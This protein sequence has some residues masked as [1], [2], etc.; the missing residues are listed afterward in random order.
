MALPRPFPRDP[1]AVPALLLAGWALLL[2]AWV[3]GNPPFA[4]PD[5]VEHFIRA[6]GVSEGH[7]IGAV[8]RGERTAGSTA[9]QVAW[10]AQAARVVS[11][12]VG[13]NP[14]PF[15]ERWTRGRAPR[16]A[17]GALL[18]AVVLNRVW[19]QLY[20]SHASLDTSELH[21]GLVGGVHEWWSALTDLVGSFGYVE[22]K[23]PLVI[24]LVWFGLILALV[25]NAL[26]ASGRRERILLAAV[27]GAGLLG[28][29]VFF[30]LIIRPTGFGLQGR[31]VLPLLVA[32]PLL[33]GE[34]VSRHRKRVRWLGLLAV[35]TPIAVGLMQALAWYVNA[36]RYAVGGSGPE[37]FA[38][39]AAWNPPDGWWLWLGAVALA[40]ACFAAAAR[41]RPRECVSATAMPRLES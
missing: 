11:L 28:P 21:A 4:A 35:A 7:L 6:V 34:L 31:H 17:A 41:S 27:L 8:P 32:V 23:L 15:F 14:E 20:G 9:A 13:L 22:V 40:C 39:S 18:L 16:V 38:G 5:E 30:A 33:A 37:W 25:A 29:V 1:R 26:L 10:T 2:A 12:P 3:V 19:E 24:P 36:K